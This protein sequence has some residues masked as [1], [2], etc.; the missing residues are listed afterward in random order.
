VLTNDGQH[1]FEFGLSAYHGAW[2]PMATLDL[3]MVGSDI[4]YHYN[5]LDL[6]AEWA[7]A[8]QDMALGKYHNYSWFTQAAYRWHL[9]EPVVR[10]DRLRSRYVDPIGAP[11]IDDRHRYSVGLNLYLGKFFILKT[12]Y[13]ATNFSVAQRHDHRFISAL[14]AGF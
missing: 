7:L 8:A 6:R 5:G 13:S 1:H 3:N 14:T 4:W 10:F 12:S 9:Y 2:N 11:F